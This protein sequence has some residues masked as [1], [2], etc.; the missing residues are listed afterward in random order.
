MRKIF[1]AVV[2]AIISL[3]VFGAGIYSGKVIAP[4]MEELTGNRLYAGITALFVIISLLGG[5]AQYALLLLGIGEGSDKNEWRID[6]DNLK[7]GDLV[8]I[9]TS[10]KI[11]GEIKASIEVFNCIRE[12]GDCRF[13]SCAGNRACS[14]EGVSFKKI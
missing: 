11:T 1:L 10:D 5:F 12:F 8:A 7:K 3:G 6:W 9:K 13:I 14:Y 4:F 2:F